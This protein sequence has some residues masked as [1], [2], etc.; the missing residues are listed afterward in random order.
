V[1][2]VDPEIQR[3]YDQNA[4]G[5]RSNGELIAEELRARQREIADRLRADPDEEVDL[6]PAARRLEDGDMSARAEDYQEPDDEDVPTAQPHHATPPA[7]SSADD[8]EVPAFRW[9]E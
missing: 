9:D 3:R 6:H 7:G 8:D 2:A 5:H 1:F 4:A